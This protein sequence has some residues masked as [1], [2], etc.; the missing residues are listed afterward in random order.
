MTWF[1]AKALAD[2]PLLAHVAITGEIGK[3]WWDDDA[4][5]ASDFMRELNALGDVNEITIDIN[6]PGGSVSDGITIANYLRDHKAKV[7]VNVLGQASSIASVIAAAGDEV[8]M[9]LGSWMM[10][11]QPWT[12]AVGNSD[13]LRALAGDLDKIRDGLMAHY[14]A[15]VGEGKREEMLALVQ[16]ETILS[17]EDAV[18]LGLADKLLVETK[19]AASVSVLARSM[20][21]AAASARSKMEPTAKEL[22]AQDALAT[23]FNIKPEEVNAQAGQLAEQI[24]ALRNPANAENLREQHPQLVAGIEAQAR[25]GVDTAEI[26]QTAVTAE[27]ARA[28][29]IIKACG[30]TGQPQLVDKLITSGMAQASAQEYIFDVAAASGSQQ[31]I[32]NNHSPEGGHKVGIDHNKIYARRNRKNTA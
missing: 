32:N 4:V 2:N 21:L 26:T 19:A 30:T 27:R 22:S 13:E 24:K 17:A 6:S 10:V 12:V 5:A 7:T 11:H 20:A 3:S 25:A 14:V 31:H 23:A 8:N 1:Q 15:R 28:S 18:A 29:A 9:G 16:A